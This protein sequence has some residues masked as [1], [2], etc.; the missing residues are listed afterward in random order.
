[1]N[2]QRAFVDHRGQ[3]DL[4]FGIMYLLGYEL[5]ARFADLHKQKLYLPEPGQRD[6]YSNLRLILTRPIEFD[7]VE[8]QY[9][10]MIKHVTALRLGTVEADAM[11]KRFTHSD[12]MH[13]TYQAFLELGRAAETIF[14]CRLLHSERNRRDMQEIMNV[15]ENW[16]SGTTLIRFGRGGEF[17]SSRIEDQEISALS[18]QLLM[19]SLVYVNTLMIQEVLSAPA[20]YD[21]MTPADWRGI[22]PLIYRHINPYGLFDLNMTTRLPFGETLH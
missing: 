15:I 13:P 12:L 18:L 21:R 4:G 6:A 9:D 10:E 8:R 22:T 17:T 14:L 11:L 2:I 16:N 1:M 7:K 5:M 20:W 19:N 3:S